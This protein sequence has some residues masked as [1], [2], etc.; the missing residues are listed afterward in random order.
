MQLRVDN[1]FDSDESVLQ[2]PACGGGSLH[3][4]KVEVYERNEDAIEGLRVVVDEGT[5]KIDKKA[6]HEYG[7]P[8]R[9]RDGVRIHFYCETCDD[10]SFLDIYQHKGTTFMRQIVSG[11]VA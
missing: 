4:S 5:A 11:E 9:R 7:N 1:A 3:H 8:S 6:G 10:K 2:C